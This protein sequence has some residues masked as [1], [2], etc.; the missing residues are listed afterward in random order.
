MAR[1]EAAR[2]A[3]EAGIKA[4]RAYLKSRPSNGFG[5]RILESLYE[6]LANTLAELQL[7]DQAEQARRQ[8][9]ALRNQGARRHGDRR[10]S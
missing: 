10:T 2:V 8:A 3:A 6:E 1:L 7:A 4:Q 5:R 9:E